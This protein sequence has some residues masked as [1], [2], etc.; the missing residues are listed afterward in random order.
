MSRQSRFP[1]FIP[2]VGESLG[3]AG[4][5]TRPGGI[6]LLLVDF[7]EY[8]DRGGIY[9]DPATGKEYTDGADRFLFFCRAAMESACIPH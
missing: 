2:P 1:S 6:R 5:G 9:M 8:F 4:Y 7:P 3:D